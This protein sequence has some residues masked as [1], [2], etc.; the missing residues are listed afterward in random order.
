MAQGDLFNGV[1]NYAAGI[2]NG[3]ADGGSGGHSVFA[4]ALLRGLTQIDKDVFTAEEIFHDFILE[5]VAGG[6]SQTPEY[7]PIR[8][9][10]HESGDFVFV[11]VLGRRK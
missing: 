8:S 11:R 10:G 5:A 2:F 3:V 1:V 9:S 7:N 4:N 6:A